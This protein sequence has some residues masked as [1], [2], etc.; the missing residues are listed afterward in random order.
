M[1]FCPSHHAE[2]IGARFVVPSG[3]VEETRTT[4]VP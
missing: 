4:G 2:D 1:A 3:L